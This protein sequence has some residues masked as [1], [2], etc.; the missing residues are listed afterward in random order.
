MYPYNATRLACQKVVGETH[1]TYMYNSKL[2]FGASKSPEIFHRI[3]Q[4]I[5][6]MMTRQGFY[7]ILAY[8]DDFLIISDSEMQKSLQRVNKAVK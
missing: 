6:C 8:L 2:P 1:F 4:A 5:A 3:M 7:T